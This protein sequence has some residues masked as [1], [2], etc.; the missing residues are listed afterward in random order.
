MAENVSVIRRSGASFARGVTIDGFLSNGEAKVLYE[1]WDDGWG[2]PL[3]FHGGEKAITCEMVAAVPLTGLVKA[4][5]SK[6][7]KR[8]A[9]V[10]SKNSVV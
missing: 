7:A 3:E 2:E 5:G 8:L 1:K 9:D 10:A 4:F 6:F